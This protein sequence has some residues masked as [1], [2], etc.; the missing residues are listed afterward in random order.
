MAS[1]QKNYLIVS[2]SSLSG[3]RIRVSSVAPII[4]GHAVGVGAIM[5]LDI[6]SVVF[7]ISSDMN[8]SR[9]N[10]RNSRKQRARDEQ[11]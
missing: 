6:S 1:P 4:I 11:R 7:L 9:G 5:R 8:V 2:R 10:G 3:V